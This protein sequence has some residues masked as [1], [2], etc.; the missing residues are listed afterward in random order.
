MNDDEL[1]AL[2]HEL[3]GGAIALMFITRGGSRPLFFDAQ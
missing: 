3:K 1:R 2:I